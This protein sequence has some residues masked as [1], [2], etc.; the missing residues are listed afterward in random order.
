MEILQNSQRGP[1]K[2]TQCTS[3]D[4]AAPVGP[5]RTIFRYDEHQESPQSSAQGSTHTATTSLGH[6]TPKLCSFTLKN[7]PDRSS[8]STARRRSARHVSRVDFNESTALG[9]LQDG[10]TTV[11][12]DERVKHT[13]GSKQQGLTGPARSVCPFDP[14]AVPTRSLSGFPTGW[15]TQPLYPVHGASAPFKKFP[16]IS[17]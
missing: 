1:C 11:Q 14:L 12:R 15:Q 4:F 7:L 8:T 2:Q 9:F 10:T 3:W 17:S 5:S 13:R 6:S 16:L